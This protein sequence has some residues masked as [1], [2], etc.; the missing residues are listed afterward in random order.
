LAESFSWDRVTSQFLAA[1]APIRATSHEAV[2]G[3]LPERAR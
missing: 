2:D 1:L 3:L